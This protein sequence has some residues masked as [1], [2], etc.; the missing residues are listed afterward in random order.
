MVVRIAFT[1]PL[2][3]LATTGKGVYG[4]KRRRKV[5]DTTCCPGRFELH[6]TGRGTSLLL[7]AQ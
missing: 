6:A 2:C 3:G 5:F 7:Y 4:D 1:R